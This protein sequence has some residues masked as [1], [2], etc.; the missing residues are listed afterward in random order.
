MEFV[1]VFIK[2][3]KENFELYMYTYSFVVW[4]NFI[5]LLGKE[6]YMKVISLSEASLPNYFECH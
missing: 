6:S 4:K 5:I 3:E 2:P 1:Q